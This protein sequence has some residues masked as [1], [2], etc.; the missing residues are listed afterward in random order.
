MSIKVLVNG[1]FGRMG[2]LGVAPFRLVLVG[3]FRQSERRH[4]RVERRCVF[5]E[6]FG[7]LLAQTGKLAATIFQQLPLVFVALLK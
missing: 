4:Y 6:R 7:E 1:A 2:Q 5:M 3:H